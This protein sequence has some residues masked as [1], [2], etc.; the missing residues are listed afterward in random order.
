MAQPTNN[1]QQLLTFTIATDI[2]KGLREATRYQKHLTQGMKKVQRAVRDTDK[3]FLHFYRSMGAVSTQRKG[4]KELTAQIK[5][6]DKLVAD[7]EELINKAREKARQAPK[8][9]QQRQVLDD[10]VKDLKETTGYNAAREARRRARGAL[11]KIKGVKGF[12]VKSMM[13]EADEVGEELAEPL[14]EL[15]SKDAPTLMK[16]MHKIAMGSLVKIA[17]AEKYG[18]GLIAEG[19]EKSAQGG[20]KNKVVGGALKTGGEFA[21]MFGGLA[22]TIA[23]FGPLLSMASTLMMSFVKIVLDAEHA[24]KDFN[25]RILSTTS[26]SDYLKRSF[27]DV[28]KASESLDKTLRAARD[29][30]YDF[31]NVQWGITEEVASSFQSAITA[32]GV[33]LERLGDATGD[34]TQDAK[35]H[36]KSIQAAVAYSR[37]F[38]VSLSEVASFQGQL[39]ADLG[40]STK[41]VQA[42]FQM[43]AD[44]A[45]EAGM[46]TNKFFGIIRSFS[47]DLSLFTLRLSEVSKIMGVLGKTMDPRKMGQFLQTLQGKFSG[48]LGE[49][50]KFTMLAGEKGRE[51]ALADAAEK[52][53]ALA[54]SLKESLAGDD[55]A[56]GELTKMLKSPKY[57]FRAIAQWLAK[58]GSKLSQQQRDAI[59]AN[60]DLQRK[61]ASGDK[62]D[63]AAVM[64]ALG[65]LS[66]LETLN[67]ASRI[68]S[69]EGLDK[70]HGLA[71]LAVESMGI[72]SAKEIEMFKR[73]Q[74][75]IVVGQEELIERVERVRKE[76]GDLSDADYAQ[77]ARLKVK[78]TDPAGMIKEL[79]ELFGKE[80]GSKAFFES[81]E[82]SNQDIMLDSA[83]EIDFQKQTAGFQTSMLDRLGILTDAVLNK[84]YGVLEDVLGVVTQIFGLMK[85]GRNR[86]GEFSRAKFA[87]G[88]ARDPELQKIFEEATGAEDPLRKAKE[89]AIENVS[90]R[91]QQQV[92]AAIK[93][94]EQIAEKLKTEKDPGTRTAMEDRMTALKPALEMRKMAGKDLGGMNLQYFKKYLYS[95]AQSED[96][97]G[98]PRVIEVLSRMLRVPAAQGMAQG[99]PAAGAPEEPFDVKAMYDSQAPISRVAT[100][101][102]ALMGV[103][104][105]ALMSGPDPAGGALMSGNARGGIVTGIMRG[106]AQ[107]RRFPAPAAGEGW[108]SVGRGET[109]LPA[110]AGGRGVKVE[111]ELKGDLRRFIQARVV[112]GAAAHDSNKR[113]R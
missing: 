57:D 55:G 102:P 60:N 25:K 18:K 8:G 64:E 48:G 19:K 77:L 38:G 7:R 93:E 41:Q 106:M 68:A 42:G 69:K 4:F 3:G 21:K 66:K 53:S 34:A 89:G 62:I 91:A 45:H 33:A 111:L 107:V 85:F 13:S 5:A 10:R 75:S 103:P 104:D 76:G 86:E 31:S 11:K 14:R 112:E 47:S 30:A 56:V 92:A 40:M 88:K 90:A 36:A 29:G 98:V 17:G 27:G 22:G 49:N 26:T 84:I 28:S 113:L 37:A 74:Q 78:A 97:G 79:R 12:D 6:L 65:P 24:A 2:T 52:M 15:L 20:L 70:L 80:G 81:L 99:D 16:R 87:A 44:G 109:I 110:G 35:A 101:D 71:L 73:L 9:S 83:K 50:I 63:Q 58:H 95:I 100:P 32:E 72:A 39:M 54:D 82:K 23:K 51:I 105:P 43:I 94:Y 96:M 46:K 67:A 59:L 1:T 108:A 61:L